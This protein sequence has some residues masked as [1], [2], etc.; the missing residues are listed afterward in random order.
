MADPKPAAYVSQAEFARR[1][2]VSKK[3]VTEW[4]QRG[5]L[6]MT[7][8]GLV[9]VEASEW[10]LDQRP[11]TY[12]GGVARRPVR[13]IPRDEEMVGKPARATAAPR[14][15][16]PAP[17][18]EQQGEGG[19][20][21]GGAEF[22]PEDPNLSLAQAAQRKEN[23]L[24][25][26]RRLEYLTKQG[27]LVER[28]AAEAAFFEEGRAFRDALIAWPARV[29]IEMADE[30]KIDAR[31]LTQVLATYVNQLLAELGEPSELDLSRRSQP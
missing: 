26:L 19:Q 7:E 30:L 27:I 4:K 11:V 25:L 17:P 8:A 9:D 16:E 10:N 20:G 6:T 1:R 24:G 13:A 12:R 14:P 23:H 2:G 18:P 21:D 28:A 22:D 31:E 5:L 3:T 29:S 15:A